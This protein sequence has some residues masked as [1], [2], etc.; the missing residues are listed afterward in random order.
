V[1]IFKRLFTLSFWYEVSLNITI[2][3]TI[4][5][6]S[7]FSQT[8]IESVK[9]KVRQLKKKNRYLSK[10]IQSE[11]HLAWS[12]IILAIYEVCREKGYGQDQSIDFTENVIFTNMKADK[13]AAYIR[14]SL[15]KAADPFRMMVGNSKNQEK[16]FFGTT[17]CFNRL[18]DDGKAYLSRISDCFYN[19]YFRVNH[20]PELMKIACKW[21]LISW[22]KGIIPEKH[23][24]VFE[25]P[26]TLGLDDKDCDFSFK[27]IE[28]T[29]R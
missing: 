11:Y 26:F 8:D 3:G 10:D 21:D 14:K 9:E 16:N 15:D 1:N 18:V 6:T 19:N 29:N 5:K 7:E 24:F 17:F 13:I 28:N 25:R 20:T 23:G 22:S 12:S 27:R 4:R 2:W